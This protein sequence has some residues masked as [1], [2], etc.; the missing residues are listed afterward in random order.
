MTTAIEIPLQPQPQSFT[1]TLLGVSYGMRTCWNAAS[2]S[3]N[4]DLYDSN[5][6][7]L[8]GK[9]PLITGADL[10]EQYG[11]LGIG[12]R[13]IVYSDQDPTAVPQ[14]ADLGVTGHLIFLS[15]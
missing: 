8:L 10:L 6:N 4:L 7:Q 12:G 2:N 3:W 14:F 13:L 9:L 1:V 11:Y 15:P 5:G